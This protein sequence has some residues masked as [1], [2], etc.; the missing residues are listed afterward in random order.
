L[1]ALFLCYNRT[2]V[3]K[4]GFHQNRSDYIARPIG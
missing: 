3:W 1:L 2:N 4:R